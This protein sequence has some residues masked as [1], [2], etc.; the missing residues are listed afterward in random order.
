M[1]VITA[2][3]HARGWVGNMKLKSNCIIG[4]LFHV[5]ALM[6]LKTYDD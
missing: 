3:S 4:L 6:W 5:L 1:I 2:N